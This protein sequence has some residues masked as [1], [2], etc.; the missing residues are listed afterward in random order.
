MY[1]KILRDRKRDREKKKTYREKMKE[2]NRKKIKR[3]ILTLKILKEI[4]QKQ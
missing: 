4:I 1:V 3:E 2:R